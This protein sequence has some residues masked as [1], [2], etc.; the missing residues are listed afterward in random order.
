MFIQVIEGKAK[1]PEGMRRVLE[2]RRDEAPAGAIGF[3]GATTVI[4]PD[5]TVVTMA[6]FEDEEK[7]MQNSA[8]PETAAFAE[9]LQKYA[10]GPPTYHNCTEVDTFR[11]GG[12]N[13]AGF[14]QIMIGTA[15]DKAK[16]QA[17]E[18]E[19]APMLEKLRPDVIG[20]ITAWDGDWY[21]QAI[22]FTS[23]AEAREGEKKFDTLSG[24]DQKKF[25]EMMAASGE[26]RYID[27]PNPI[28]A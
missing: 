27:G 21:C 6:R 10:E 9:E 22:Y 17:A 14:V 8:R 16:A 2:R 13:D 20:G 18:K 7:A 12:S 25:Q 3:L 23:E 24:E 28:L 26:P 5:G 1:D 15:V 19:A 11:D 4:S